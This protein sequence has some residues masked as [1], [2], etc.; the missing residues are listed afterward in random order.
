MTRVCFVSYEIHPTTRGG[1]GVLLHHA[2]SVLLGTGHEVILLLD[3]PH[4][5]FDRF[6]SYDRR[7][8]PNP[9]NCRA[10]HVDSLC[11]S[12]TLRESDFVSVYA[13]KAYRL[14]HACRELVA[15]EDPQ[16]VEFF[17]YCGAGYFALSAKVAGLAYRNTHLTVRLHTAIELMDVHDPT[18]PLAFDRY[19]LYALEHCALRLAESV[20]YPSR[21]YLEGSYRPYYEAWFGNQVCSQPPLVEAP[22]RVRCRPDADVALFYGR[23]FAFKGV[24]VFVD[25]AV[26][27]LNDAMNARLRFYLAGHDSRQPPID[28]ESYQAYLWRKI[29]A[30][31]RSQFVFTGH[32]HRKQLEELLPQV[33]FGVFPSHFE[34][35]CYAAHEIYAAG[36]PLIVADIPGFREFFRHEVNAL[37]CDGS[38]SDLARQM[39]RMSRDGELRKRLS[40]PFPVADKPLG[41]FYAGA[42][43]ASWIQM[44]TPG[45]R[46]TLLVCV[47]DDSATQAGM[48][49]AALDQSGVASMQIVVLKPAPLEGGSG[50]ATWWLGALYTLHERTGQA[51]APT[52]VRTAEA[53]VILRAGDIPRPEYLTRCLDVMARQDQIAF[54][55]SWKCIR[56]GAEGVLQTFPIE[57]LLEVLPFQKLSAFTRCVMRTPQGVLLIDLFDSRAGVYGELAYLWRL[58]SD[59]Q[60]GLTIPEL[61]MSQAKEPSPAFDRKLLPYLVMQ[62]VSPWRKARWSRYLLTLWSALGEAP[63]M[64]DLAQRS[65]M[66]ENRLAEMENSRIWRLVQSYR[67]R[68]NHARWWRVVD[69]V[70]RRPLWSLRQRLQSRT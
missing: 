17:D 1:C 62:D 50:S 64:I 53:L 67:R 46:P 69:R 27:Y 21:D 4:D 5:Y 47:I 18:T 6:Q 66:L 61:L 37:V 33:L 60:C 70:V 2:A 56:D 65:A 44:D 23:L 54:V 14:H 3:M 25:A 43:P 11:E 8:L 28:V 16:V 51:L 49:L 42:L 68:H 41:D 15:R 7:A 9:G 35:F 19:T 58:D 13:W 20:V 39:Q 45:Q 52:A 55:G 24:D 36:I 12:L 10:Y 34:S 63:T 29:P 38:V 59:H 26:A 22:P 32:L 30:Q 40:A 48:T 57:S 31:H